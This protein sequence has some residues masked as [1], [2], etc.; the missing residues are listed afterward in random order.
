MDNK[1]GNMGQ[2]QVPHADLQG[3]SPMS[4]ILVHQRPR[5]IEGTH[6]DCA[7]LMRNMISPME[8]AKAV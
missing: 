5:S 7:S 1:D 6:P 8:S 4:L 3:M 2:E